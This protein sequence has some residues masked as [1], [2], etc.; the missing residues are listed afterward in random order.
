MLLSEVSDIAF[1]ELRSS[2][3]VEV[4]EFFEKHLRGSRTM[5]LY[6]QKHRLRMRRSPEFSS[7]IVVALS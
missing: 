1:V 5:C 7:K 2:S 3:N 6:S 4:G